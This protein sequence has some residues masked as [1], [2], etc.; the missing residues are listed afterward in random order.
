MP[1]TIHHATLFIQIIS[2]SEINSAEVLSC[3]CEK[4][5][6]LKNYMNTDKI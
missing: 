1:G 6:D 2:T 3:P 5:E 4:A